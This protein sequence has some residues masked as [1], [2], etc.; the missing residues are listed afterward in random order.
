[1]NVNPPAGPCLYYQTIS[2]V[3]VTEVGIGAGVSHS[4]YIMSSRANF[5]QNLLRYVAVPFTYVSDFECFL[6]V[7]FCILCVEIQYILRF[8]LFNI[9]I[10]ADAY[11]YMIPRML[12]ERVSCEIKNKRA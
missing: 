6:L 9:S 2:S 12:V 7:Y 11:L 3:D 4:A 8:F 10:E 1:M 5:W